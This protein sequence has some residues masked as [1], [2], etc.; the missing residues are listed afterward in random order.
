MEEWKEGEM[1]KIDE[2]RT[3]ELAMQ[4]G[5]AEQAELS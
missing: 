2:V 3:R 4:Y 5:R 1:R